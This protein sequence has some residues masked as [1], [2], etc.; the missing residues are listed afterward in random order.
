M[1]SDP[2]LDFF[3]LIDSL[4]AISRIKLETA[5]TAIQFQPRQIIY[6]EGDPADSVY[7]VASGVVEAFTQSADGRQTRSI[8]FMRR[9]TFFGDLAV[10][11]GHP[12]LAAVR[13]C[14][15]S[16]VFRFEKDK[17][18]S[19]L[20][21]IPQLGFYFSRNLALRLHKT[22]SEANQDIFSLD[23]SGN[24]RRFDLLT[25]FQAI[26]SMHHSG[27]LNLNDL[28]NEL[29]GS[30]FFRQGK[31]E[32]A[33]FV[34]LTGIEA[35]WQGFLQSA[36]EGT[37]VFH[38]MEEPSLSSTDDHLIHLPS[39]SVLIE[40][41]TRRDEYQ[42]LPEK[43][44]AMAGRLGQRTETLTWTD[45]TSAPLAGRLWELIAKSPQPLP[46]LWRRV[47][48]SA[49]TFLETVQTLIETLQV[50]WLENEPTEMRKT[51]PLPEPPGQAPDPA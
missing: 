2:A 8:A 44:R 47:N 23:L 21:N 50:N 6:A 42:A 22:S 48:Y 51:V 10:L 34:H 43:L 1:P 37:F 11:T 49:L 41:V 7:I 35:V 16:K 9:G 15:A 12:R 13:A 39:S 38:V 46:S 24:L 19:L 17:F 28:G 40:G 29:I 18:I 25:I 4:D 36:T 31:I 30:F 5:Y 27:E 45:P 3:A 32:Q 20:Q 26:T 14:E 33:R